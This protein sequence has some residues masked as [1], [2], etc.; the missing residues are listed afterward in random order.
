MRLCYSVL[1]K[2]PEFKYVDESVFQRN[3]FPFL[4]YEY[5]LDVGEQNKLMAETKAL[6]VGLRESY[7][8][9]R[10]NR[11]EVRRKALIEFIRDNLE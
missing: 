4:D 11:G 8:W 5:V 6:S 2:E 7:E 10:E 1:G 9:Y 3:Y